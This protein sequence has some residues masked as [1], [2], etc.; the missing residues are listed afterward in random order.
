VTEE[1]DVNEIYDRQLNEPRQETDVD[2]D[3]SSESTVT[4]FTEVTPDAERAMPL[5]Y[6]VEPEP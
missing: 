5:P 4:Q 1:E 3:K 2:Q 6:W